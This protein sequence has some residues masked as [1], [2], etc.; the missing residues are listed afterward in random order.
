MNLSANGINS[1]DNECVDAERMCECVCARN[2]QVDKEADS[3]KAYLI[4]ILDHSCCE[5]C[6]NGGYKTGIDSRGCIDN[7]GV[8]SEPEGFA[9]EII[10]E[11]DGQPQVVSGIGIENAHR[12]ARSRRRLR[13]R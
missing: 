11:Y 5:G 7:I 8:S 12:K 9:G 2:S 6:L 4:S 3:R 10:R 1:V 13:C